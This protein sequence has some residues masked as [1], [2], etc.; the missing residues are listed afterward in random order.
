MHLFPASVVENWFADTTG[1]HIA[2][3]ARHN[4]L[5][6]SISAPLDKRQSKGAAYGFGP[7]T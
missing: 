5:P 4:G 7:V 2:L 1:K 6:Y 3:P